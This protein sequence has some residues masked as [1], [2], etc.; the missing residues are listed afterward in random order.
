[1]RIRRVSAPIS[2]LLISCLETQVSSAP[3]LALAAAP[4]YLGVMTHGPPPLARRR[5][6]AELMADPYRS[7][8]L[9]AQAARCSPQAARR[10]RLGLEHSGVLEHVKPA[11]RAHRPRLVPFASRARTALA[12][13]ATMPEQVMSFGLSY[14][15]ACAALAR[16]RALDSRVSYEADA[17]AATDSLSVDK[18]RPIVYATS[19]ERPP[20]GYYQPADSIEVQ[21]PAC[22]LEWR[23]GAFRH[24]RSCLFRAR[25]AS[26]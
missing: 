23:D 17:A 8:Y 6:E 2:S 15:A 20:S 25:P 4:V 7:N 3:P 5:A 26:R 12:S 10:W 16:S 19:A 9:I 24:E 21:C 14:S 1:L 22:T 11:D 18:T 13:G